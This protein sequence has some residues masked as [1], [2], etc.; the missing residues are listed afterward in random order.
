[1]ESSAQSIGGCEY[2]HVIST[3]DIYIPKWI[4]DGLM[5]NF[6]SI[7]VVGGAT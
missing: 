3:L 6:C 4:D 5:I 7:S 1:M 2:K